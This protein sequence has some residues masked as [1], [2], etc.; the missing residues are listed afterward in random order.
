MEHQP[1]LPRRH[2]APAVAQPARL[3]VHAPSRCR[4]KEWVP[5]LRCCARGRAHSVKRIPWPGSGVP[6]GSQLW[7]P[8]GAH[9]RNLQTMRFALI[10]HQKYLTNAY[11]SPS[12]PVGALGP[13][14][15]FF[16]SFVSFCAWFHSGGACAESHR[17]TRRKQ[18]IE[19]AAAPE[20]RS[21]GR[22]EES[23][24]APRPAPPQN[25][26]WHRETFSAIQSQTPDSTVIEPR[27]T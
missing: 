12:A 4:E 25:S 1:L 7:A 24:C 2:T 18:S 19:T 14:G 15:A 26:L 23:S 3:R 9:D 5:F 21:T 13:G 22:S 10:L 6:G 20:N 17:R 8:D 16:V 27:H 11:T